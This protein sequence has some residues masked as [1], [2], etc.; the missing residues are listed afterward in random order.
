MRPGKGIGLALLAICTLA[1]GLRWT[2]LDKLQPHLQEA[3]AHV[4]QQ[5]RM[6]RRGADEGERTPLSYYAYPTLVG[7]ALALIPKAG[8]EPTAELREHLAT[9]SSDVVRVRSAI[10]LLSV[11][12]VPLT[13]LFARRFVGPGPALAAAA[14]IALSLLHLLFSQQARLHGAQATFALG[15]VLAAMELRREPT[16]ARYAVAATML[17]LSVGC[18]HNGV[19]V[20]LPIL[21]AHGLRV[22]RPGRVPWWGLALCAVPAAAVVALFYPRPPTLQGSGGVLEFGGHTLPLERLDGSGFVKTAEYF[23]NYDPAL[24]VLAAVGLATLLV[25]RK[26]EQDAAARSGRSG[27]LLVASCYALP[28]LLAVGLMGLTQDRFLIPLLPF[29]ATLAARTVAVAPGRL[30]QVAVA[31]VALAFPGYV[32]WRYVQVRSAPD[33]IERAAAW[34]SEHLEPGTRVALT[35]RLTLPLFHDDEALAA[36]D[37][38]GVNRKTVWLRYQL[39]N[40]P[41]GAPRHALFLTPASLTSMGREHSVGELAEWLDGIEPTYAI[42]EVSRL[43][44]YLPQVRA[45]REL[46]RERG[47]PVTVLRGEDEQWANEPPLDYQEIPRF[48]WRI[49]EAECFGPSVEIYRL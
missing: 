20:A 4:V 30:A 8:V 15:G 14:L 32:T 9:A 5:M 21:A 3:D 26:G 47:T 36:A 38:D 43:T 10:A 6:H 19:A 33:T 48:V 23:W 16:F 22:R 37:D 46:V 25:R 28:Y 44:T 17:A 45:L 12:L 24:L 34:V 2:G 41:D 1:F 35:P 29:L 11:L 42:L 7:R 18:L 40:A 39:H 13:W 31:L 27:D 49:L